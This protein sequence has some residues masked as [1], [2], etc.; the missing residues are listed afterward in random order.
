MGDD[1]LINIYQTFDWIV[2]KPKLLID[3]FR[4]GYVMQLTTE[5]PSHY[6]FQCMY[7]N[8]IPSLYIRGVDHTLMVTHIL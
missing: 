7:G 3:Y 2:I 6:I 1:G 8:K 4:N 5:Q